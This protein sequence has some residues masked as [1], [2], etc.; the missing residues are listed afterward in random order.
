MSVKES[1]T[2]TAAE[3]APPA[4]DS[5]ASIELGSGFIFAGR[6]ARGRSLALRN[7]VDVER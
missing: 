5:A 3:A 4:A 1:P 7:Y 2:Y 6:M